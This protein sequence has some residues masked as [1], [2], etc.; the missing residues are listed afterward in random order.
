MFSQTL[1]PADWTE[2]SG[3]WEEGLPWLLLAAGEVVHEG[4]CDSEND[5]QGAKTE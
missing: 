1:K 3:D 5:L 2:P 4:M